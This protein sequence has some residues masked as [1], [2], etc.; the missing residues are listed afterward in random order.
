MSCACNRISCSSSRDL[1]VKR[2]C[3]IGKDVLHIQERKKKESKEE[4]EKERR[5]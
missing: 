4:T 1:A 2:F 3:A 5:E